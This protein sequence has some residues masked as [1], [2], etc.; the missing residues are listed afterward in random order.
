MILFLACPY[1]MENN[2]VFMLINDGV[3]SFFFLLPLVVLIDRSQV[4]K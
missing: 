3:T 1:Y 4:L 2:K